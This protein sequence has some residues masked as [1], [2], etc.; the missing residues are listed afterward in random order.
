MAAKNSGTLL[1]EVIDREAIH[2]LPARYCHCVW[3]KDLDGY[4]YGIAIAGPIHRME[5]NLTHH[6]SAI[7]AACAAIS[8]V[9]QE[10]SPAP[11]RS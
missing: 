3:Q 9:H 5:D 4:V 2:T 6:V 8:D 10:R 1:Q 11:R 7:M